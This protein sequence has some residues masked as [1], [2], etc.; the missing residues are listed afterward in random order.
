MFSNDGSLEYARVVA[1]SWIDPQFREKLI[2]DPASAL[3]ENG[4]SVPDDVVLTVNPGADR[5]R[6][7]LALPP[8]P[9]VREESLERN[10]ASSRTN[11][12]SG[13]KAGAD[14][15]K[16]TSGSSK[17]AAGEKAPARTSKTSKTS[18]TKKK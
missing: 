7:D 13:G 14:K 16:N 18:S 12:T 5:T 9:D 17:K 2:A 10:T 3:R 11:T 8:R 4:I 6:V 15:T 1:K